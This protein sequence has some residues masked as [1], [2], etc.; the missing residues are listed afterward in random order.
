VFFN[1]NKISDNLC[2]VFL[3]K[4]MYYKIV[5]FTAVYRLQRLP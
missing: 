1:L 3:I 2:L 4:P 5:A